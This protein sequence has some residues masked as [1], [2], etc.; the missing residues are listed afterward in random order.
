MLWPSQSLHLSAVQQLIQ[1][2][3][4]K[5]DHAELGFYV[6]FALDNRS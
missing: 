2:M 3:T 4:M 5:E 6:D 1:S